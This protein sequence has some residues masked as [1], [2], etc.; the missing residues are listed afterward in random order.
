MADTIFEQFALC[1][2]EVTGYKV[3]IAVK[4][5]TERGGNRLVRRARQN[6]DGVKLDDTGSVET[7]WTLEADF[8]NGCTE[9]GIPFSDNYPDVL[10]NFVKSAKVH[11]TGTLTLPTVGKRRVRLESYERSES[12]EEI[13]CGLVTITF[14]EDNEDSLTATTFTSPSARSV[15]RRLADLTTFS[16]EQNGVSMSNSGAGIAELAAEVE[17]LVTS[18]FEY[19]GDLEAQAM[20]VQALCGRLEETFAARHNQVGEML[21]APPGAHA[22]RGLITLKDHAARV[23]EERQSALP[24]LV[25]YVVPSQRSIFDIAA[26]FDQ[27][28]TALIAANP[29]LGDPLAIPAGATV[30]VFERS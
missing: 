27:D 17:T 25:P 2:W 5:I 7:T 13:D 18:P 4:K 26:Q 9:D 1:E 30:K 21:A 14:V 6:R 10:S 16:A 22:V 29:N 12:P 11:E 3:P 23:V 8:Y 28:P 24:R 15:S 20:K 19:F